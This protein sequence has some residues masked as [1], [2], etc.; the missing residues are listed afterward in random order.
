M[1]YLG[2]GVPKNCEKSVEYLLRAA[3]LGVAQAQYN[4]GGMYYQGDGVKR[5]LHLA[6]R[7]YELAARQ[8]DDSALQKIRNINSELLAQRKRDL[9]SC[10]C[11][12]F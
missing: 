9:K 3:E 1:Y 10:E 11:A 12:T 2:D 7:Y 4:L 6:K 8:G 5:D